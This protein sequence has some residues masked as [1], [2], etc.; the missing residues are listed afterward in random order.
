MSFFIFSAKVIERIKLKH[1]QLR[2]GLFYEEATSVAH[3]K[4]INML[5]SY[6]KSITQ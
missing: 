4:V 2:F 5:F 6:P 3:N 1:F